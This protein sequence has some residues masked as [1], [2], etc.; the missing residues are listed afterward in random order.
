MHTQFVNAKGLNL[1]EI[2]INI[3]AWKLLNT[4]DRKTIALCW[5]ICDV[6]ATVSDVFASKFTD[7]GAEF[8]NMCDVSTCST[9]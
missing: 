3:Y 4:C 1:S 5:G 6:D 9:D 2:F 7:F 8:W